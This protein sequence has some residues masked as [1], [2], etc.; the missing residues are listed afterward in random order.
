MAGPQVGEAYIVVRAITDGV[1]NDIKK[2]FNGIDDS[3]GDKVGQKLGKSFSRGFNRSQST[4]I[5][6]KISDGLESLAPNADAARESFKDLTKKGYYLQTIISTLA[7]AFASVIGGLVGLAGT[8]VGAV[9]AVAALGNVMVGLK[10]GMGVA[11]LALG[12]VGQA[13]QQSIQLTR[14]YGSVAAAMG[15]QIKQLAFDA[16]AAALS[17]RRA[18]LSLEQARDNLLAAQQLPPNSRARREAE[19]AYEEADLAY[20]RAQQQNK[21]AK[22]AQKRGPQNN[23]FATLTPSQVKFANFMVSLQ[24]TLKKLK[25][26]AASGFLPILQTQISKI[27]KAYLP[28]LVDGFKKIGT[29]VGNAAQSI[30][31][32]LIKAE[33]VTKIKNLFDSSSK[34]IEKVGTLLSGLLDGFLTVLDASSPMANDFLDFLI[35]KITDFNTLLKNTDLKAFF[36]RV[37]SIASDFGTVFGN[38]FDGLG[39][40]VKANFGP[41]SGGQYL[42]DWLKT[43]TGGWATLNN[44]P[45]GQKK[46]KK[47][48]QDVAVNAK[49]IF[50][51]IGKFFD[52]LSGLGAD[53]NIGLAFTKLQEAAPYVGQI[54]KSGAEAGPAI[55]TMAVEI[56]KFIAALADGQAPKIFFDTISGALKFIND[57]LKNEAVKGFIDFHGRI[58]AVI[59]AFGALAKAVGFFKDVF[60][61]AVKAIT[62]GISDVI[63]GVKKTIDFFKPG[64][65]MDGIR[66]R[67]MYAKDA[68]I[69][70][71]DAVKDFGKKAYDAI[72]SGGSA[73]INWGKDIGR[74]VIGNIKNAAGA[75]ADVSKKLVLNTIEIGKNIGAW[76]AQKAQ[77]I[78]SAVALGVQ[79]AAQVASNIVTA[80]ATGIQ[81]AFNAVMALNPIYLIVI[82][83]AALVAGLI[84]FF[85][86]TEIGKKVWKA[87]TDFLVDAWNNILKFFSGMGKWFGDLWNG[88]VS[89]I[90]AA[91]TGVGNFFKGLINGYIGLWEGF[92]NF[93]VDGLN[94]L[95]KAANTG[96]GFLGDLIGQNLEIALIPKVVLPRLAKGGVVSPSS[97]GS[98]VNVAEAGKPERIEPLD[99]NGLS[100]RDKALM[101][102]MSGGSTGVTINVYAGPEMDI[103]E[104]ATEVSRRLAFTMR[105]GAAI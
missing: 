55:A 81:A 96:L 46:L 67:F 63:G 28:T 77:I 65:G 6:G 74:Y 61:G 91:W 27:N 60:I 40:I 36:E 80:I 98:L 53:P 97:G 51:T 94:G 4:N 83:V 2:G 79:K 43:A 75:I 25:E 85:T 16:E 101:K 76:I 23:P 84:Y 45:E 35:T 14:Q 12:G 69:K 21:A 66:L 89:G 41:D 50:E 39:A 104:L 54:F 13:I 95:L 33:N 59:L 44:S 71:K 87:F 10:I 90:Q 18:G 82:A 92:I 32:M 3:V 38:I 93:L 30:T 49:I 37:G 57:L 47:Y 52:Q 8:A 1:A 72:K 105:K 56:S 20:R 5:F 100:K 73:M 19:L 58:I 34:I 42:L 78:A 7:G 26:A 48:F 24:G 70:A 102:Q 17:E 68:I 99:A 62:K 22:L 31:D 11:K 64:G 86:Q 88:I 29:S 15:Q 103:R 9:P